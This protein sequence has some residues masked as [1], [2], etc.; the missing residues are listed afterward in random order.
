MPD[1]FKQIM[2]SILKTKTDVLQTKDDEKSY[3]PFVVNKALSF[4]SDCV[5]FANEMNVNCHLDKKLQYQFLLY[6]CRSWNRP[7]QKWM[8]LEMPGDLEAVKFA[9]GCS[10]NKARDILEILS[11]DQKSELRKQMDPGGY[12]NNG[13]RT[14]RRT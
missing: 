12:N 9:Y 2:P 4:H 11:E 8:K 3:V 14:L 10:D 6:T 1:L 5:L 13:K 7:F